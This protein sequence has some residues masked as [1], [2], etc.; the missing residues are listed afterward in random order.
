MKTENATVE[1]WT[2]FCVIDIWCSLM[3][4]LD[5]RNKGRTNVTKKDWRKTNRNNSNA[6]DL[7]K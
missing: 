1:A 7:K 3:I 2:R 4:F 5:F 6:E